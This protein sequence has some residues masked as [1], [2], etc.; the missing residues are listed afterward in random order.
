MTP[1]QQLTRRDCL[2]QVVVLEGNSTSNLN[3]NLSNYEAC[4]LTLLLHI[5]HAFSQHLDAIVPASPNPGPTTRPQ[6]AIDHYDDAVSTFRDDDI[7]EAR[8]LVLCSA[9]R[10]HR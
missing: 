8:F 6:P 9:E 1:I 5:L 2:L 3:K 10:V 4:F 7:C